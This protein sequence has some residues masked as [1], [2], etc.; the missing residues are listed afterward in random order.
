MTDRYCDAARDFANPANVGDTTGNPALGP[1][2][3]QSMIEGWGNH[4]A[5]A[6]GDDLHVKGTGDQSKLVKITVDADKT[7]TWVIGDVVENHN[8]GGGADGDDWVGVLVYIDATTVWAQIDAASSDS[9]SVDTAD[10]VYNVTRTEEIAGANMTAATA[11]GIVYDNNSGTAA[12]AIT[13]LGVNDSWVE[14]GT[15]AVLDAKGKATYNVDLTGPDYLHFRNIHARNSA[16][17]G[18]YCSG[19]SQFCHWEDCE[20]E[21]SGGDAW[22][23]AYNG[24]YASLHG[25]TARDWSGTYGFNTYY[26]TFVHCVAYNGTTGFFT[27]AGSSSGCVAFQC[28]TGFSTAYGASLYNCVADDNTNGVTVADGVGQIIGCRITNNSA[29][30]VSGNSTWHD[31]Y[32]FYGGNAA[33][34][35]YDLGVDLVDGESTRTISDV[36]ADIGYI[37]PDNATPAD[38][39]Y[40]LTNQAAARR[41][42]VLL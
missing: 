16:S 8:D 11:P 34:W 40:G 19:V 1:G 38:R 10:G 5:L 15:R 37:D 25:C 20:T 27:Y 4:D 9:D 42:A 41:Q 31:P 21:G 30:G 39:N 17:H 26:V 2:G 29:Y 18:W 7:G 23:L 13:T 22:R 35:Q 12:A 32:T 14:D 6:S 3:W 36:A 28:T 24:R 33:N